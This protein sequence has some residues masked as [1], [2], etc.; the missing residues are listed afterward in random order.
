MVP[1]LVTFVFVIV[2]V[3]VTGK[4]TTQDALVGLNAVLDGQATKFALIFGILTMATS[5]LMVTEAVK[6][7]LLWD[8][9]MNKYAAYLLAVLVPY[10][11]F[12]LGLRDLTRVVSFA[13]G[14]A[15]GLAA[16]VLV[17]ILIRTMRDPNG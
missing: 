1:V 8:L 7:T 6:E 5:Y 16:S 9:K 2:V 14:V 13:G 3:A 17:L 12:L 4:G 11:C 15:G 10:L